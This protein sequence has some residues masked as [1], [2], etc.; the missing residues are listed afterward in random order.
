MKASRALSRCLTTTLPH[1]P[2]V[3]TSQRY[4]TPCTH[5]KALSS[6]H[7]RCHHIVM[8]TPVTTDDSPCYFTFTPRSSTY[9]S[10]DTPSCSPTFSTW[11]ETTLPDST[12]PLL[13]YRD[14]PTPS[15]APTR[16]AA[17]LMQRQTTASHTSTS[18]RPQAVPLQQNVAH[19]VSDDSSS[20]SSSSS[21]SG[22]NDPSMQSSLEYARCS[23]CHRQPSLDVRTG[24]SNMIQYGL[25]LWYCN[26]CAGMVGLYQR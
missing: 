15:P 4:I 22:S 17:S 13:A 26:R 18:G 16:M 1:I 14:L 3:S 12:N 25:N 20:S 5:H 21:S 2:P 8:P 9:I 24:K 23:R 6:A 7:V 10:I 11:S 19:L